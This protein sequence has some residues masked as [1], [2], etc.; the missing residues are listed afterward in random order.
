MSVYYRPV[1]SDGRLAGMTGSP[2]SFVDAFGMK[3]L[4]KGGAA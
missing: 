3:A 4:R 1:P 2:H